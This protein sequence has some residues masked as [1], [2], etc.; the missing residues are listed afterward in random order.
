MAASSAG[1]AGVPAAPGLDA[2]MD[3]IERIPDFRDFPTVDEMT[4]AIVQLHQAYPTI[5]HLRRIG[6]SRLGEPLVCLTVGSGTRQ[7]L[8]FAMPHPNEPIG[9][10]TAG[11]L[12]RQLCEDAELRGSLDFTWHIVP[13]IDPDGTRLNEG[14]FKGPF[15]RSH[16]ARHFYRP[17]SEDQVEW[18]FPFSYKKAYFDA[19]LPE[20]LALMRLIDEAKPAFLCSLHNAETGGVYYYLSRE[21]PGL[22]PA[23]HEIP[24]RLGLPLDRGEPEAPYVPVL[25][26]AIFGH[27][28]RERSYDYLEHAGLDPLDG[29]YGESSS[30][31]AS[32]YGTLSLVSELPYWADATA[33]DETESDEPYANVL[34]RVADEEE[35]VV[36]VMREALTATAPGLTLETPFLRAS[37]R[38][39]ETLDRQVA[40]TRWRADQDESARPATVAELASCRELVHMYRTRFPGIL[41][42]ALEAQIHAG[43]A[44]PDVRA[45]HGALAARFEDWCALADED[46]PPTM[47]PPRK[48]VAT[49]FGA[50]IASARYLEQ[51]ERERG[52]SG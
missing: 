23:L 8:I 27:I 51:E 16:Y 20:T 6:S 29:V 15:T 46:T 34:R 37:R 28:S 50:I 13:C 12:A 4:A 31:Y 48:L 25:A 30:H 45:A 21:A 49:Q 36:A 41:V 14:W 42:R 40:L 47:L 52:K 43:L 9:A 2:I 17:A 38:F 39:A 22:Y 24:T 33:D 32:R 11:E 18:T 44:S 10:L 35:E 7:A 5:T 19:V 3:L 1:A 26:P